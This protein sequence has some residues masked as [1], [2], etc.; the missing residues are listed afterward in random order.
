MGFLAGI[1]KTIFSSAQNGDK[2]VSCH[3]REIRP[4]TRK[5]T[6]NNVYLGP[7]DYDTI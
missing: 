5:V 6:R 4:T 2:M 1:V 3:G 7:N